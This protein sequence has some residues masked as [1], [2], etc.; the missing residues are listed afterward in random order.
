MA[1]KDRRT[2]SD[3]PSL[4]LPSFG[5][6]RKRKKQAAREAAAA[7]PEP[8]AAEPAPAPPEHAPAPQPPPEPAPEPTHEVAPEPSRPPEPVRAAPPPQPEP[9]P[10]PAPV[11]REPVAASPTQTLTEH[12]I[13]DDETADDTD[14]SGSSRRSLPRLPR[15]RP[16]PAALLAGLITGVV[17]VALVWASQGV[18]E[19]ARGTSSCGNAGFLLLVAVLVVAGWLG[20]AL[21]RGFGVADGGSTSFLAMGLV[22]VVLMLFLSDRLFAWW[23]VV[24]V[25]GIAVVAFVLS[26][27]VT[28]AMV[29]PGGREMH[30]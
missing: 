1:E 9:E 17:T 10:Q 22:A 29:E 30:R 14:G 28:T 7:P 23:V 19:L 26:Q 8:D 2:D 6:G 18:C 13:D 3:G 25:P 16:T 20:G 24:A 5:F 21:L 15:L 27:R 12:R 4:E 11:T